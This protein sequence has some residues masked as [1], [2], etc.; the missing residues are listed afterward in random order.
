[1]MAVMVLPML[2]IAARLRYARVTDMVSLLWRPAVASAAMWLA[3]RSAHDADIGL[4]LVSL[5]HDVGIGVITF[6]GVLIALWSIAG[7]PHGPEQII[8]EAASGFVRARL[9]R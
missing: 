8:L 1:M 4:P 3:V 6:A 5:L 2:L 9:R 7:R